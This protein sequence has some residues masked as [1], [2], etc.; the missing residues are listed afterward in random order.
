[1]KYK[2]ISTYLDKKLQAIY[3]AVCIDYDYVTVH[4]NTIAAG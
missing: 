3:S 1:M 2:K 4:A